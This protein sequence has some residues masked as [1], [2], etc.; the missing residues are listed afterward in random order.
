MTKLILFI[1]SLIIININC[2]AQNTSVYVS[3]HPDDWQLFYNPNI[4]YS[5]L[6]DKDTVIILHTT[7]GDAGSGMGNNNYTLA[8]EEGSLRGM[9]FIIN[10]TQTSNFE[11]VKEKY[12][13]VNNHLL[14]CYSYKNIIS[15]FMRLPDGGGG[16][17]YA[18]TNYE[19]LMR[20]YI[21]E[22]QTIS[23]IDGSTSYSSLGDLKETIKQLILLK[24][25]KAEKITINVPDTDVSINPGDHNDHRHTSLILQ[26]VADDIEN[27]EV[28]LYQMYITRQRPANLDGNDYQITVGTWGA[29]T[30]GLADM[31]HNSTWDNTHNSWVDKQ[32]FRLKTQT[33]SDIIDSEETKPSISF[34][35]KT[36]QKGQDL[37]L[38]LEKVTQDIE[39]TIFGLDGQTIYNNSFD[40]CSQETVLEIPT[41]KFP[42]GYNS[43]I[44][45]A[46]SRYYTYD[47]NIE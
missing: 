37:V 5:I 18:G 16:R 22:I 45:F 15:V 32:Y 46:S 23:A 4:S 42:V 35:K 3:P 33:K 17:G 30:S 20:F 21:N 41:E 39:L 13:L 27:A 36:V 47:F 25:K 28:R 26:E 34:E 1:F 40:S 24:S 38:S 9:R 14:R 43:L 12:L 7:A 29:T 19:S 31:F 2:I 44:V 8:R 11:N 6:D 10:V